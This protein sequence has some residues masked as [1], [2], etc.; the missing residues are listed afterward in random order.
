MPEL[1]G[2]D[3]SKYQSKVDWK[4]V[5]AAG[6]NFAFVRLGWAGWTGRLNIDSMAHNH[7]EAAKAAGVNVGIYVYS[8]CNT[9]E[10]ARTAARETLKEIEIYDTLEYPVVFDIEDTSDSGTPYHKFGKSL[11][12]S[13]S[14]AFLDEI[15]Q[16]GYYGMLYTYKSFAENCLDMA[17]LAKYDLWIAQY[18]GACTYTGKYGIWQYAGDAGRCD[19]VT[20][21]CDLNV[22][23]K[24]YAAIIKAAGRGG[25]AQ[26]AQKDYGSGGTSELEAVKSENG[27]LRDRIAK[28]E[29]KLANIEDILKA[30]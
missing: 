25:H 20:G 5:K 3:V 29:E 15:E 18:A 17:A 13:I 6:K 24:D 7:I 22:S 21:A 2:I 12:T 23:Y 26:F 8:Y 10:A 11:C 9:A 28:L 14:A 30:S 1:F 4:K 16:A 27:R 19:G